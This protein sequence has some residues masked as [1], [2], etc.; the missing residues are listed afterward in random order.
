MGG[1]TNFNIIKK[2]KKKEKQEVTSCSQPGF[3]DVGVFFVLMAFKRL[4]CLM[5]L[6]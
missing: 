3:D 4:E 5:R 6:V 1:K 2:K